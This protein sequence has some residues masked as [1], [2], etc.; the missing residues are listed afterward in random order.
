MA[1]CGSS[2]GNTAQGAPSTVNQG[3]YAIQW[4]A[5]DLAKLFPDP[6]ALPT[7]KIDPE[8][9][10]FTLFVYNA[11][12][13][14]VTQVSSLYGTG[15][16]YSESVNGLPVAPYDVIIAARADNGDLLGAV[17]ARAVFPLVDGLQT[18]L[19]G[20]FSEL[21]GFILPDGV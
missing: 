20:L 3:G 16:P 1:G 5:Q 10:K 2:G 19:P 7:L 8:I 11:D 13:V 12:G 15:S 18:L 4:S 21:Q 14:L 17:K 9:K 6:L